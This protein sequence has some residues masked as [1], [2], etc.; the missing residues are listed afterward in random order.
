MSTAEKSA[1]HRVIASDDNT[2]RDEGRAFQRD[3]TIVGE[4]IGN[5]PVEDDNAYDDARRVLRSDWLARVRREAAAAELERMADQAVAA[6]ISRGSTVK[7]VTV[8]QLRV[9]ARELREVTD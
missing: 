7:A 4:I 1:T 5:R 6:I 8:Q 9:R 3:V 2:E